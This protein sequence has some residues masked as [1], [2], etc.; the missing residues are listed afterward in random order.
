MPLPSTGSRS[1]GRPDCSA[2]TCTEACSTAETMNL[3][4]PLPRSASA[5]ASVPP[6]V[7][8]TERGGTPKLRA[9]SSRAASTRLRAARPSPWTEEALPPASSAAIIACRACG[10]SG[11]DALWSRYA[12]V[13]STENLRP[14]S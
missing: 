7:N 8:T 2:A 4:L 13:L 10:R 6:E 12:R 3:S 1:T 11:L 5:L 9:S 14:S